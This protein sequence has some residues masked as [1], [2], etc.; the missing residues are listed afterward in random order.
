MALNVDVDLTVFLGHLVL[1]LI[2][3]R[4]HLVLIVRVVRELLLHHV[5]EFGDGALHGLQLLAHIAAGCHAGLL[6]GSRRDKGIESATSPDEVM[7]GL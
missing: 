2:V 7:V 6:L 3:V 4:S 1:H 5:R